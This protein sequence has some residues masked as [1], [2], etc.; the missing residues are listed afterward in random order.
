MLR[1]I[2]ISSVLLF[3]PWGVDAQNFPEKKQ[4]SVGAGLEYLVPLG[5]STSTL[6]RNGFAIPIEMRYGMFDN[7]AVSLT[8]SYL[9]LNSQSVEDEYLYYRL[10]RLEAVLIEAGFQ[11]RI[12]PFYLKLSAGPALITRPHPTTA[13]AVS[14]A[15]G[16]VYRR[17]EFSLSAS[18]WTRPYE[19]DYLGF[20]IGYFF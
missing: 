19:V 10:P 20:R 7:I 12:Q 4:I 5:N 2:F 9:R 18:K 16:M 6:Y 3:I 17:L 15:L 13:L 1:I 11:Y 8:G 14:P